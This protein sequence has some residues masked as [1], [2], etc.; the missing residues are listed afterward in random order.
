MI[1]FTEA[2]RI[3]GWNS[4]TI[5]ELKK[6]RDITI[7]N[8]FDIYH[9]PNWIWPNYPEGEPIYS[10]QPY[11]PEQTEQLR[12]TKVKTD[13][14]K[15]YSVEDELKILRKAIASTEP[16]YIDYNNDVEKIISESNK[17]DFQI[18]KEE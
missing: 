14:R 7:R 2:K 4:P 18:K 11:T 8:Q 6:L 12:K 16:E 5:A 15:L 10:P 17:M 13:I 1:D 3:K 9:R